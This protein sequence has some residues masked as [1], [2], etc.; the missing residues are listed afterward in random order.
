MSSNTTEYDVA[1]IGHG[2]SGVIA[3]NLLGKEGVRTLVIER[4][5]DLYSRARAVTVNDW[6]LRIFQDLGID[7]KV[8]LDMDPLHS[9]N[10][11][12]YAGK[13]VFSVDV[14][15]S[16]LSQ[17]A[18]TSIYQPLMEADLRSVG[19]A[20]ESLDI[21]YGHS[22]ETLTQ[23]A[24][25][26]SLSLIDDSGEPY[27]AT[28]R[29][30]IGAD[31]GQSRTR[32]AIGANLVGST[33]T[34]RWIIID[35][36]VLNWWRDCNTLNM[37]CDTERPMV[38]I[39]L[40]K[41]NH[42]W[43]IPLRPGEGDADFATEESVWELLKPLG[44]DSSKV[45]IKGWAF[46]N[47][48]VRHVDEWRKGRVVL[49]GDA[50]HLMPPWAGQGMQSGIRDAANIAWKLAAIVRGDLGDSV[51]DSVASE[52][53]PHVEIATKSA[54]L[55]GTIVETS[56]PSKLALRDHLLPAVMKIPGVKAFASAKLSAPDFH[57]DRGWI[58]GETGKRSGVG[59]MFPQ[60]MVF[61]RA[62]INMRLDD[63]TGYGLA[64]F[65]LD[66]DPA[67]MMSPT[68]VDAWRRLGARFIAVHSIDVTPSSTGTVV[69]DHTGALRRWFKR[70]G[71]RVAV[72]RPDHFVAATDR[73][74]LAVPLTHPTP[75]KENQ[76]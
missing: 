2:P 24:D 22:F 47:H 14:P 5:K 70:Y 72:V 49:V 39:P 11:R 53:W 15:D 66:S 44:M 32:D 12:T 36:Q 60:P 3:A 6:T 23:H 43:E 7:E 57:L 42:R 61:D 31:G 35:G 8:K 62:A 71:A 27:T 20:M 18:S 16:E 19:A 45:R 40:A 48:H 13:R 38:D 58:T 50:A 30:V 67:T 76:A 1:I 9:I 51:L 52:R 29:Y 33:K 26:V 73:T 64:V 37:W 4:D 21:R 69:I 17:P 59:R 46:Y 74:G 63:A 56:E 68:E 25:H 55:L 41:G 34:R 75:Y 54:E 28:A 65:G 10:W